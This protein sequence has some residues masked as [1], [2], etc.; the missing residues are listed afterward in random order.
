MAETVVVTYFAALVDAVGCHREELTVT[1]ATVGGL[2]RA[3]AA[4]HGR[5]AG[6]LAGHCCV[7]DGDDLLRDD[8]APIGGEVDLLPPFAGG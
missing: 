5:R 4:R 2:R 7:L 8:A 3:V 6:E 1:E